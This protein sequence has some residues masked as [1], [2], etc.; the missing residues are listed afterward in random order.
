ME[1]IQLMSFYEIVRTGSFSKASEKVFRSQSAISHQ[2]KNL[3]NELN[4]KLFE[5]LGRSV[6]LTTEGK[7]LLNI[8][9]KIFDDLGNLTRVYSDMRRG[10]GGTLTIAASGS[11]MIYLMPDIIKNFVKHFPQ[12]NFRLV[13]CTF[14]SEITSLILSGDV[15]FG[16]GVKSDLSLPDKVNWFLWKSY[17]MFLVIPKGHPL[18]RRRT[19]G[20]IDI[21]AYPHILYRKG[22]LRK[23]VEKTYA[24]NRVNIDI[25]MEVD[26]A[27]NLKSYV[28]MGI[29]VGI[30]SSVTLTK[31][32]K[33]RFAL[34][35]VSDLFGKVDAGIYWN[36]GKYMSVVMKKFIELFAPEIAY[37]IVGDS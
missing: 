37:R 21:A 3:E 7:M 6:K 14:V 36:K 24:R 9:N 27:E 2:I 29:G 4:V 8:A 25:R 11:V 13:T 16:V 26:Y 31:A 17:D 23:V 12:V 34:I 10:N 15:D 19:I 30:V 20:V 33:K 5:R 32:D 1:L 18:S 22:I 35:N 28:D